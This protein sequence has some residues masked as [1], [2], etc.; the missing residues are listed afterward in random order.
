MVKANKRLDRRITMLNYVKPELDII[1]FD[2][3]D[4]IT[5]SDPN[6]EVTSASYVP[7]DNETSIH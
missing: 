5:T 7:G 2:N 3:D 4:V 6:S 1:R